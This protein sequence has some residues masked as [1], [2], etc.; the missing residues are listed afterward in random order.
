MDQPWDPRPPQ[1]PGSFR[2]IQVQQGVEHQP[3][4]WGRDLGGEGDGVGADGGFD[5]STKVG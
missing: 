1:L 5:E 3:Q 2:G 4:P